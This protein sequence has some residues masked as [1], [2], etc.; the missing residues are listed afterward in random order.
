MHTR[1]ESFTPAK[2]SRIGC[3][4]VHRR[5]AYVDM[6]DADLLSRPSRAEGSRAGHAHDRGQLIRIIYS[7]S[8]LHAHSGISPIPDTPRWTKTLGPRLSVQEPHHSRL[9]EILPG[10]PIVLQ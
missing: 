4:V 3:V 10:G 8:L 6:P 7:A 2:T 9:P 5:S 1:T